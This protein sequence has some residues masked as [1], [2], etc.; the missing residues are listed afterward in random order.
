MGNDLRWLMV[1]DI[2][3]PHHDPRKVDLFMQ[4]AKALKPDAI[5]L[6]G[7][8]D[9]A[10]TTS[11]WAD[12]T[13]K[14]AFSIED[15]GVRDTKNFLMEL[16]GIL[17]KADKHFHDGNHGWTRHEAYI[18]KKAPTLSGLISPDLL[19]GYTNAGFA[20]HRYDEPPVKRF[21]DVYAHHGE[22]ISKHAG[23][24]V[25]NDVTNWGVSLVRGH[26]HR[27]GI[28]NLTY[29]LTGQRL[30][31]YEIGHLTDESKLTYSIAKN[32]QPGFA[33]A[34]VENGEYPHIQLINI[35]PDYVCFVDGRK[36]QA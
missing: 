23:E 6:L 5:D 8:I 34:N 31:G 16:K 33:F 21:G 18:D 15:E 7:D 32:W 3:F 9:N 19:Y 2:H 4:V 30:R 11:R 28:Y 24:S 25:R 17:P 14:E 20:W 36:F 29:D 35:S 10:D 1:S 27:Q 13:T 26:S 22:A 12:G